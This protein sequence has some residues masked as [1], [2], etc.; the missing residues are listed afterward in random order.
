M[1][2]YPTIISYR[3]Q[4]DQNSHFLNVDNLLET[5]D[6]ETIKTVYEDIYRY[7][8]AYEL[9]SVNSLID[10]EKRYII[11]Q[12]DYRQKNMSY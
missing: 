5:D 9:N 6:Y 1:S 3:S 12:C 2:Y 11:M 7:V 8:T 10:V 4:S